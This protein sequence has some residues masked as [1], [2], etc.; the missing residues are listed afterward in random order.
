MSNE[1]N[2][3]I[4][5]WQAFALTAMS[6]SLGLRIA[7]HGFSGV[8]LTSLLVCAALLFL[9][10]ILSVHTLCRPH[11]LTA[12]VFDS[13]GGTAGR[14]FFGVLGI[15]FA[16]QA[17]ITLAGRTDTIDAFLLPNTPIEIILLFAVLTAA[18][19]FFTGLRQLASTAGLSLLLL[20]IPLAVLLI[21]GLADIDVQRLIPLTAESRFDI[22]AVGACSRT[23]HGIEVYLFCLGCSKL[24]VSASYRLPTA[25]AVCAVCSIIAFIIC[26]GTFSIHG[27]SGLAYPLN[28]AFRVLN[29]GNITLSERFDL[30]YLIIDLT[31][32]LICAAAYMYCACVS[33]A[34]VF[35]LDSHR[36]LA[37]SVVP[38][39][40]MMSYT[41][42]RHQ[43]QWIIGF[44]DTL[45]LII[46]FGLL[47]VLC[48]IV[49]E[50]ERR[51]TH[52]S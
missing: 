52:A 41:I 9:P 28:E 35:R 50:R 44:A 46:M 30:L 38:A 24:S 45:F 15:Y 17:S 26:V 8:W 47:P 13:A 11:S 23:F 20:L 19:L 40:F 49:S 51:K 29:I 43:A 12:A 4:T 39:V 6:A 32:G 5:G 2:Y 37:F 7:M 48:L 42:A 34:C 21:L 3:Q 31:A 22:S 36:S 33:L 16:V 27:T 25:L 10:V 14:L 18:A 1:N